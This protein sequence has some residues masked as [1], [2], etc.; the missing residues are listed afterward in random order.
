MR[1]DWLVKVLNYFQYY[2]ITFSVFFFLYIPLQPHNLNVSYIFF[3]FTSYT[4]SKPDKGF[5]ILTSF[6]YSFSYF[7]SLLHT[8]T[9]CKHK[10]LS[11]N[12]TILGMKACSYSLSIT[13]LQVWYIPTL[14]ASH[15]CTLWNWILWGNAK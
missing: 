15:K 10:F 4:I 14:E 12:Y 8:F 6:L 3:L 13:R 2:W 1:S 7:I 9:I 5:G 11:T